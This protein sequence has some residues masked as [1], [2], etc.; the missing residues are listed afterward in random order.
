M[1][2]YG[3]LAKTSGKGTLAETQKIARSLELSQTQAKQIEGNAGVTV[4]AIKEDNKPEENRRSDQR[5]LK[6]YRCGQSGHFVRDKHCPARS[7]TC[8]K[9]HLTGHFASVCRT[10]SKQEQK[11]KNT[12]KTRW[13]GKS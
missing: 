5:S 9:C 13:K 4:N 8:T 11:N 3:A 12:Q 7:K 1:Q 10:K 6:G 2:V